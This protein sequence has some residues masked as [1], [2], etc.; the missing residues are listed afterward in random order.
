MNFVMN[1]VSGAGS[2]ARPVDHVVQRATAVPR[3]PPTNKQTKILLTIMHFNGS[4]RDAYDY[5]DGDQNQGHRD[6]RAH[7]F[8][9][10]RHFDDPG[11]N[12]D[13]AEAGLI[14]VWFRD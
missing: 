1:H 11:L 13:Q 9:I 10:A 7:L 8:A 2:N 6:T 4:D 12:M 14:I 3:M 5:N